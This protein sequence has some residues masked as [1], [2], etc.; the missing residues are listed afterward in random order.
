MKKLLLLLTLTIAFMASSKVVTAYYGPN[1]NGKYLEFVL[2]GD[3]AIVCVHDSLARYSHSRVE[4]FLKEPRIWRVKYVRFNDADSTLVYRN[5]V[6]EPARIY[7]TLTTDLS[8]LNIKDVRPDAQIPVETLNLVDFHVD[9][10]AGDADY[11]G[12]PDM[13]I[14]ISKPDLDH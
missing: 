3:E 6:H 13:T 1:H 2:H 4:D 10:R 7:F 11:I 9:Y 5:T 14:R 12:N 8:T